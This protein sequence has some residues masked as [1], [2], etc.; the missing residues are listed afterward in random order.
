MGD[1]VKE[2]F[3]L[4]THTSKKEKNDA[5]RGSFISAKRKGLLL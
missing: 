2:T 4:G 5:G 3:V 1:I